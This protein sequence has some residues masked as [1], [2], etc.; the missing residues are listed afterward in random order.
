MLEDDVEHIYQM[1][2]RI[3]KQTSRRT[4]KALQPFIHSKIEAIQNCN[5]I[6]GQIESSQQS[7]KRVFKCRDPEKDSTIKNKKLKIERD[8]TR[9]KALEEIENKPHANLEP[10]KFKSK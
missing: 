2:A 3:E 7:A 5:V 6:K 10:M 1:A 9:L 4:N 8:Q